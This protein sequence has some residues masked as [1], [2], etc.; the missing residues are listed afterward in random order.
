MII[1][2]KEIKNKMSS[3]QYVCGWHA[4]EEGGLP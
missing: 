4:A 2:Q 1:F 3:S